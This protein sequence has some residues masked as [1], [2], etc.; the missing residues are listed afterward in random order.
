MIAGIAE[1]GRV[2]FQP[3]PLGLERSF[4]HA[5]HQHARPLQSLLDCR[6]DVLATVDV[7]AVEPDVKARLCQPLGQT[8]D[9]R[10]VDA[11]VREEYVPVKRFVHSRGLH[12]GNLYSSTQ[13][14]AD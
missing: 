6:D 14:E 4:G 12:A 1:C 5:Q 7:R 10:L 2:P 3:H 8:G 11:A 9:A 13:M